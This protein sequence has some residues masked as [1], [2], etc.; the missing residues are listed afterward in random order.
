M[1]KC[2]PSVVLIPKGDRFSFRQCS[3]NELECAKMERIP[4]ASID[5]SLIYAQTYT[6]P[7][8][9]FDFGM[10]GKYQSNPEMDHWKVLKEV[11]RYMQGTKDHF[12][13]YRRS[14]H[15]WVIGYLYSN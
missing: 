3:R 10:P 5:E 4:Y 14:N 1:E 15:L 13:T 11:L 7:Y 6:R 12:L 9:S 2:S 8:T